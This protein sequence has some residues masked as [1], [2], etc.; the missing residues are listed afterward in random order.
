M[1]LHET[2]DPNDVRGGSDDLSGRLEVF[3]LSS[4]L[5]FLA[6]A[7]FSGELAFDTGSRSKLVVDD[8]M[9]RVACF[10]HLEGM[11]AA[12][13]LLGQKRGQFSFRQ[14]PSRG[15]DSG[16][17]FD[18]NTMLME[19]VRLEDEAERHSA[20]LPEIQQRLVRA[21]PVDSTP[22]SDALGCGVNLVQDALREPSTLAQLQRTVSLCDL[23]V[24]LS[25][26]LLIE[27]GILRASTGMSASSLKAVRPVE[28]TAMTSFLADKRGLLRAL[29]ATDARASALQI[30]MA[31][32]KLA[33]ALGA[34]LPKLTVADKGPTF[35][36]LRPESGGIISLTLLPLARLNRVLFQSFVQSADVVLLPADRNDDE[37]A[38]WR[39]SILPKNRVGFFRPD[40]QPGASLSDEFLR[41]VTPTT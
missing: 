2:Q 26:A 31:L 37:A 14:R 11:E 35:V 17:L 28:A 32:R 8:G 39:T 5:Q 9:V 18:I 27:R 22:I 23:K 40:D 38:A 13:S 4:V 29:V 3:P 41:Q 12:L 16:E 7:R 33:N 30:E 1:A 10:A 20:I 34:D 6:V 21:Q 25:V 15:R 36:R 24:S 19:R